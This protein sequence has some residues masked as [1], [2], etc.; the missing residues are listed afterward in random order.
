M[1]LESARCQLTS[2]RTEFTNRDLLDND[3]LM[4]NDSRKRRDLAGQILGIGYANAK[5][6][7]SRLNN[8]GIT[9]EEFSEAV[10]TVNREIYE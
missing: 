1:A 6:F 3:L 8:Y 2:K 9:R 7:L 10:S 5:Q 4:G